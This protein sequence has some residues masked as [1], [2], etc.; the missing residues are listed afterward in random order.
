MT[1]WATQRKLTEEEWDCFNP[2]KCYTIL[3][4]QF[5]PR[6]EYTYVDLKK[7]YIWPKL[8]YM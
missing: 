7:A 3:K 4:R 2:S 8:Q 5:D 1:Q 6:I